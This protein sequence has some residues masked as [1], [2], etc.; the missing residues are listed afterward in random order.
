M[1][2]QG[3]PD[4][5]RAAARR[6]ARAAVEVGRAAEDLRPPPLAWHGT[7]AQRWEGVT[8][9]HGAALQ[10]Q[11]ERLAAAARAVQ[12]FADDLDELQARAL[13]LTRQADAGGLVLDDDGWVRPAAHDPDPAVRYEVEAREELRR[14][15]LSAS[16][17][18]REDE[19]A[20]HA[21]LVVVLRRLRAAP[22]GASRTAGED[23]PSWGPGA[24]D[25]PPVVLSVA[26]VTA[27][28]RE[29][30]PPLLRS[31]AATTGLGFG[32]GVVV[33]LQQGRDLD[34]ALTKNGAVTVTSLAAAAGAAAGV[35]A[36]PV[37]VPV[38]A[39][40]AAVVATGAGVAYVTGRAFDRWGH[41]LPWVEKPA[42]RPRR[43]A[44]RAPGPPA[45]QSQP[46]PSAG[47]RPSPP[48]GSTGPSSS[49]G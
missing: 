14:R 13:R 32:Y 43:R 49:T 9:R 24:L 1:R 11:A 8:S 35:A 31:A 16:G 22:E 44:T 5:C 19:V 6:L 4:G 28:L 30:A 10:V 45:P 36:A 20:V 17:R 26:H 37:V 25:A 42:A 21:R 34:D 33:D 27:R 3:D 38:A 48:P 47:P 7:A 12:R 2:L 29:A 23:Q 18:L 46:R 41:H 39:T 40:G 15:V